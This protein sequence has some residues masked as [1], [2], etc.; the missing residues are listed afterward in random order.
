MLFSRAVERINLFGTQIPQPRVFFDF[1]GFEKH[2]KQIRDK[3]G[4][5]MPPAWYDHASYYVI[6]IPPEKLFG[7]GEEVLVPACTNAPD[8]DFELGL[9]ITEEALLTTFAEALAFFK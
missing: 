2:V 5:G 1:L 8:Y 6:D 7:S 3:R 9:I 4:A